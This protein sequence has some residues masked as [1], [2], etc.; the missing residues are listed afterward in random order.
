MEAGLKARHETASS[1]GDVTSK[2]FIGLWLVGAVTTLDPRKFDPPKF[3][4][5]NIIEMSLLPGLRGT[6][7]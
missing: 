2:S 7:T 1:G 6:R 5:P 3:V 4:D